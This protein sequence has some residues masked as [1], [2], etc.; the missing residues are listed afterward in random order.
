VRMAYSQ[1]WEGGEKE[2]WTYNITVMVE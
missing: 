1:P 2:V